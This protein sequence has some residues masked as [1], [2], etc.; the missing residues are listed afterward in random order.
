MAVLE[1]RLA[2]TELDEAA[3]RDLL[4]RLASLHADARSD[5]HAAAEAY[6]RALAVAGDD[7]E[8]LTTLAGLH[9]ADEE[10]AAMAAMLERRLALEAPAEAVATCGELAE[11]ASERLEDPL[12]GEAA[13]RRALELQPSVEARERLKAHLE[14]FERWAELAELLEREVPHQASDE[15]R[16]ALLKRVAAL[17][18]DRLGDAPAGVAALERAAELA[19]EDREVLTPLCDV[20]IAAGRE[21]AAVPVLQKL[22][23]SYG[24]RRS[25]ELAKVHHRLGRALQ[26]LGDVPGALAAYDAAFRV[27]L[28][29]V[30]ILRDLGTLCH[31][32]G[33]FARA[34]KTFRALLLQ[35]LTPDAGITKADVY[36]YLGDISHR[37][38]DDRKAISMLER[39]LTE[40]KDHPRAAALL[41]E[42]KS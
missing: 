4:L 23:A 8:T 24:K 9:E 41:A 27:D 31:A 2:R 7:V 17:H 28:T 16:V 32:E 26:G 6:E 12:R 1:Q 22:I 37:A 5:R 25:K 33:D 11:L 38:G 21:D 19:P 42:L 40:H 39:A 29:N 3:E 35:K 15:D 13:L 14:R 20:Y 30:V 36:F 34:Q 10:W 18:M